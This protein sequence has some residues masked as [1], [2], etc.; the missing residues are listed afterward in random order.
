MKI[1][2]SIPQKQSQLGTLVLFVYNLQKT[3]RLFYALIFVFLVKFKTF[4]YK[5]VLALLAILVFNLV[6]AYLKYRNFTFYIDYQTNE[7]IIEEG[8][9]NRTKT[10]IELHKIQ[11]VSIN[12]TLIHKISNLFSV[13]FDTAGSD[14]KE[15]TIKAVDLKTAKALK[16][17]LIKQR[18]TEL[19]QEE[20]SLASD[21]P[22]EAVLNVSLL[23]LIKVG[24]TSKYLETFAVIL[25]FFNTIYENLGN[26]LSEYLPNYIPDETTIDTYTSSFYIAKTIAFSFAFIVALVL[27]V[28]LI[29]TVVTYFGFEVAKQNNS[30]LLNYGLF[31]TKNTLLNPN[32]V[33]VLKLSQNYIQKKL[34]IINIKIQQASASD[35]P[36]AVKDSRIEVPGCNEAQQNQILQFIYKDTFSETQVVKPHLRK[37]I[38]ALLFAVVAPVFIV[39]L[40]QVQLQLFLNVPFYTGLSVYVFLVI[41]IQLL[42][43]KN[44]RLSIS[45]DFIIKSHGAWDKDKSIIQPYRIQAIA[46]SQFFWQKKHNI[47]S[48]KIHTAGGNLTFNTANFKTL[49]QLANKWLY[50]VETSTKNWM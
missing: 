22:N 48:V 47:G 46:V 39:I 20:V 41:I 23:T 49:K 14:K 38:I 44:Y 8:V 4:D 24:L 26:L 9:F 7:F 3:I 40:L 34:G 29:R 35:N 45:D 31:T 33:Q 6:A 30:L 18:D 36:K 50:Q 11:Q 37:F 12:Q 27:L 13:E 17:E 42:L 5:I 19:S 43:F 25:V 28:N 21:T 16:L 10:S 1:D 2:F 32:K 15:G